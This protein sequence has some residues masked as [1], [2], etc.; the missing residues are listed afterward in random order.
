MATKCQIQIVE[1]FIKN[2]TKRI[3]SEAGQKIDTSRLS[4]ANSKIE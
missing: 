3:L 4:K 1:N 2:E